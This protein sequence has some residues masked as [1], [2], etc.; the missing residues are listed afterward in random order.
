ML[1]RNPAGLRQDLRPP[2]L[3]PN[4]HGAMAPIHSLDNNRL[5]R[6]LGYYHHRDRDLSVHTN[7]IDLEP[8][9]S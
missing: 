7:R 6:S 4:I 8:G 5:C 3:P 1:L 2:P 9:A